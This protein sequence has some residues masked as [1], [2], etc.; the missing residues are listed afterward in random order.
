MPDNWKINPV[1]HVSLR[2]KWNT[3]ILHK[4][5][6]ITIDA[7]PEAEEPYYVIKKI[8]RCRK[9]KRGPRVIAVNLALW[10]GYPMEESSWIQIE[11]VSHPDQLQ[12]YMG[13]DKHLKGVQRRD[14][15]I[16]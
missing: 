12:H 4:D 1:F 3:T 8:L 13:E 15:D 14:E 5:Q 11:Q 9:V 7:K 10:A 6:D 16:A 2:K